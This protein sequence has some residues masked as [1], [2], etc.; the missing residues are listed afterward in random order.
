MLFAIDVGNTNTVMGIF[1]HQRQIQEWRIR[2]VKD[3]TKDEFHVLLS[4]LFREVDLHFDQVS[5]TIVASVVPPMAPLLEAF[6]MKY[7]KQ[8]ALFIDAEVVSSIMPIRYKNPL[9]VG[10]DRIVN[11]IAAY[12]KFKCPLI[13]VDFG[14]AT[15][16][17]VVTE[18]GEYM[19]GA[20]TP[21]IGISAEALFQ[22]TSKLP[23]VDLLSPPKSAIGF[24]TIS[25]MKSGII[26]GYAGLV[27]GMLQRIR[28]EMAGRPPKV[29]AT[30]GLAPL[31][32][33]VSEGI[34]AIEPA[35]TLDGL[36]IISE[37]LSP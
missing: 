4:S 11:A 36:R 25:S 29:I 30:G 26:F 14:T 18:N 19:G 1:D 6:C 5:Q 15:T 7:L 12:E 10:A 8:K 17:D 32:R 13:V 33:N 31:M 28:K 22:R 27:D 16:F 35:L 24:D 9:E 34:D 20:I 23:R 21:G 37:R 2:T 3:A